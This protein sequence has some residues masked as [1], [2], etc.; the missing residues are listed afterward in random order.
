MN[1]SEKL[2]WEQELWDEFAADRY[3]SD[4]A[5]YPVVGIVGC[6]VPTNSDVTGRYGPMRISNR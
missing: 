5:H 4:A 3:A 6:Y 2:A 1:A